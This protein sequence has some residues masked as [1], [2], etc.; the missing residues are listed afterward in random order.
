MSI[1]TQEVIGDMTVY[2]TDGDCPFGHG[3]AT[4]RLVVEGDQ[5]V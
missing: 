5:Y 2:L 3:K 4:W 1:L